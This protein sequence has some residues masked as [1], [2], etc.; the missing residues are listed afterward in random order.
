MT[1]S[2][3][4]A[5]RSSL[6][7]SVVNTLGDLDKKVAILYMLRYSDHQVRQELKITVKQLKESKQRIKESLLAKGITE[8]VVY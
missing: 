3:I 4:V 7:R 6:V 2:C 8:N 5:C 1:S